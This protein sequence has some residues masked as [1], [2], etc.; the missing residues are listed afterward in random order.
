M[1]TGGAKPG[2]DRK[3]QAEVRD[4]AWRAI[5]KAITDPETRRSDVR[6][7]DIIEALT[8]LTAMVISATD[9]A[10]SNI[11]IRDRVEA[12]SKRLRTRANEAVTKEEGKEL[13][14][15]VTRLR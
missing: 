10:K 3:Y 7:E 2:T 5:L 4:A 11:A 12:I 14:K 1:M 13:F 6:E 8:D 9:A 15:S